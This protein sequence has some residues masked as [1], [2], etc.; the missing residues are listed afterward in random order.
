MYAKSAGASD[1]T[2]SSSLLPLIR[3]WSFRSIKKVQ[4]FFN[5]TALFKSRSIIKL[6]AN[7]PKKAGLWYKPIISLG[8]NLLIPPFYWCLIV[9]PICLFPRVLPRYVGLG[10]SASHAFHGCLHFFHD[11]DTGKTRLSEMKLTWAWEGMSLL[12]LQWLCHFEGVLGTIPLG[13]YASWC[14]TILTYEIVT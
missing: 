1:Q 3:P 7:P 11:F 6:G 4:K 13:A 10:F 5:P 8:D 9:S 2:T 12:V 14:G